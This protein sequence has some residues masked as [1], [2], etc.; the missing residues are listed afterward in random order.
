M[1]ERSNRDRSLWSRAVGSPQTNAAIFA[2]MTGVGC[3]YI[4]T[5][6]LNEISAFWVTFGPVFIM[7]AYALLIAL[8]RAL[9]L[10]DDQSGDNLYYMGF[11]FTLTSLGVSLF[12]FNANGAA[13]QIVQNFGVAIASTI[14]G[15]ALRV[16]FN[17]MRRDPL[18]VEAAARSELADSARRVRRELDNTVLELSHFRRSAQQSVL[19]G[20]EDTRR[21]VDEV[22]E[23]IMGGL[24]DVATR[25]A[26]P[27]EEVTRQSGSALDALSASMIERLKESAT[28]LSSET[29]RLSQGAS[30]VA[31]SLD[32]ISAKLTSMQTP[33]QVVEVKL[34]PMISGL[35]RAV[36][37][38][39]K[40]AEGQSLAMTQA[41]ETARSTAESAAILVSALQKD[42]EARDAAMNKQIEAVQTAAAAVSTA[43][44][45]AQQAASENAGLLGALG[46]KMDDMMVSIGGML[47]PRR[48]VPSEPEA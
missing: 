27:L 31:A 3:F 13:E 6:K 22:A 19:D 33:D 15:I 36:S 16:F 26:E 25:S 28:H 11:L 32:Q 14:A 46:R 45:K 8:A 1:A 41:M 17:Q 5:A 47:V 4:I 40:T 35:T 38:F 43:A 23:S 29:D 48:E 34:S 18:E 42:L 30:A 37:A 44:D 24:R 2:A 7:L 21:K 20:L 10:R 39:G 9:R 12:Q